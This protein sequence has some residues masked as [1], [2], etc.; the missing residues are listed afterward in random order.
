MAFR[1][2]ARRGHTHSGSS[3]EISLA[4]DDLTD[5]SA[6]SPAAND[7]LQWT[8]SEW[9][10]TT[11]A[12]VTGSLD[13]GNLSGL[14]DDD[15]PQYGHL[16]QNETVSGSWTFT[17]NP[18]ISGVAPGLYWNA[19]SAGTDQKYWE[20]RVAGQTFTFRTRNDDNDSFDNALRFVRDGV[21][22]DEAWAAA[23]T[24]GFEWDIPVGWSTTSSS[25]S[26][27]QFLR[28]GNASGAYDPSAYGELEIITDSLDSY[29]TS[30][31]GAYEGTGCTI[32]KTEFTNGEDYLIIATGNIRNNKGVTGHAYR[33]TVNGATT[34]PG[35]AGHFEQTESTSRNAPFTTHFV[36]ENVDTSTDDVEIEIYSAS[37]SGAAAVATGLQ[38]MAI[39][40]SD[41]GAANWENTY[42][43]TDVSTSGLSSGQYR[44]SAAIITATNGDSSDDW[45]F[46]STAEYDLFTGGTSIEERFVIDGTPR[47][48]HTDVGMNSTAGNKITFGWCIVQ[49]MA[50]GTT[51]R[52][53]F[54]KTG[55]VN[56]SVIN[57]NITGINISKLAD[58]QNVNSKYYSSEVAYTGEVT[59][60]TAF[61]DIYTAQT[62][63]NGYAFAIWQADSLGLTYGGPMRLK[64]S[65][66]G[67]ADALIDNSTNDTQALDWATNGSLA[68]VRM[69]EAGT[70]LTEGQTWEVKFKH[71]IVGGGYASGASQG[72]FMLTWIDKTAG[73]GGSGGQFTAGNA[74][75]STVINGLDT[76]ITSSLNVDGAV[77]LDTTLAVTG[78]ST[79]NSEV[80][81]TPQTSPT[82]NEGLVW[83]DSTEKALSYYNDEADVTVNM[84]Q[85]VLYRARN[86][87]G[88]TIT[89]G[90][91]VYISGATGASLPNI[92]LA[93]A[94]SQ[95]TS[96]A[97]GLATHDI[98][99]NTNG[100]V[101]VSGTV[102]DLDTSAFTQGDE[103]FLSPSVAGAMT[104]TRPTTDFVIPIGYVDVDNPTIGEVKVTMHS[105]AR[106]GDLTSASQVETVTGDW[107]I[108][109]QWD[110][111]NNITVTSGGEALLLA[112]DS[113]TGSA[114]QIYL[115]FD[116]DSAT[117]LGYVGFGSAVT[118][119]LYVYNDSGNVRLR[120]TDVILQDGTGLQVYNSGN[121][122]YV[123]FS[124]DGTDFNIV[125]TN[126]TAINVSGSTWQHDT[127]TGNDPVTITRL[128]AATEQLRMYVDDSNAWFIHEQDE[129]DSTAHRWVFDYQH[130]GAGNT[131]G[132]HRFEML[133]EGAARHRF[134][135]NNNNS[136]YYMFGG[137]FRL[138]DNG[139]TDFAT[140]DHDGTD[141]N[142]TFTNTTDWNIDGADT[143]N[144]NFT[145]TKVFFSNGSN[146]FYG[147]MTDTLS[148]AS[149][150]GWCNIL[151]CAAG[152]G[153]GGGTLM[154]SHTGGSGA[155]DVMEVKIPTSWD[156]ETPSAMILKNSGGTGISL[157]RLGY[158]SADS[159]CSVDVQ[160]SQASAQT[161]K[162]T[163]R[164]YN[165]ST[166][167]D[168]TPSTTGSTVTSSSEITINDG[169]MWSMW[170]GSGDTESLWF[171]PG[172][173]FRIGDGT[174]TD[175]MQFDH[176]GTDFR[177]TGTNTVDIEVNGL[178]GNLK[179]VDAGVTI[180]GTDKLFSIANTALTKSFNIQNDDTDNLMK[181]FGTG[182]N[183]RIGNYG[184]ATGFVSVEDGYS[185]RVFDSG[186]TDY[187]DFDHDGTDFNIT[188]NNTTQ[189]NVDASTKFTLA[190]SGSS[191]SIEVRSS[192][193][194]IWMYDTGQASDESA[195]KMYVNA[196]DFMLR[197]TTD[198]GSSTGQV[199]QLVRGTGAVVDYA[200]WHVPTKQESF[201]LIKE[202]SAAG[203]DVAGYGQLWVKNTTP[204]QLW[205]TDDAGTDTQIV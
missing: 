127:D 187:V 59:N 58:A 51:I 48:V 45:L 19:T 27:A 135:T 5:V 166:A 188:S 151:S 41:L 118:G 85:E 34:I 7:L 90:S 173:G 201:I 99:N 163:W 31:T 81:F 184:T 14:S 156:A 119:D 175:Y 140:F 17:A 68:I 195:Y 57:Q 149:G 189:I 74:T 150:D 186:G 38:L 65:I 132:A 197:A 104:A 129:T 50:P 4:L 143:T 13:H 117:R 133:Y 178:S 30:A 109:G 202:R 125:G 32:A 194:A 36:L 75:Y 23:S 137:D 165:I 6:S 100:F 106:R 42:S 107:N 183:V 152:N 138:Y 3:G 39:N 114:A 98:E 77:T 76:N 97:I 172:T 92:S 69:S 168:L 167:W 162:L 1:H 89:N 62:D 10:T 33:V 205:F 196:G 115:A 154:I 123:D 63:G 164:P 116:D 47:E 159:S 112:D 170:G 66:N 60:E 185:F 158:N 120:G 192:V 37:G 190:S 70:A 130:S 126:T 84:G 198:A 199:L 95:A 176:D 24:W 61:S 2:E 55:S 122:D 182:V 46:F 26:F 139:H 177:L 141:F 148:M 52:T 22:V 102:R 147:V 174:Q 136:G 16:S 72:Y 8:G 9:A 11:V 113:G 21:V 169:H 71:D 131:A 134:Y 144:V 12:S 44:D 73:G 146:N 78:V 200:Q 83:Y 94:D 29:T 105:P 161:Y 145:D 54:V 171:H 87:T 88:S 124:H 160:V 191:N 203:T 101:C 82:H 49:A 193:P 180:N 108:S 142:L 79:F 20:A 18:E 121:T 204:C 157:L 28:F 43:G 179:L 35:M 86:T 91:V 25:D 155:P 64:G 111:T 56:Y 67:G 40:L 53:Q 96:E 128:G 153:R 15:H 80:Q 103:L 181:T 110:F 93:Q